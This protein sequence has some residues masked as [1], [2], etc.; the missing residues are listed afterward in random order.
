MAPAYLPYEHLPHIYDIGHQG[1]YL[2]RSPEVLA[3]MPGKVGTSQ[4]VVKEKECQ[5]M[6]N[7]VQD[8]MDLT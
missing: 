8:H 7:S 2:H 4:H 5:S 6:P 3:S 1:R